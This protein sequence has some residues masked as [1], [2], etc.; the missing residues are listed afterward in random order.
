MLTTRP[1]KPL[2]PRFKMSEDCISLPLIRHRCL[3]KDITLRLI[4]KRRQ[5]I[6]IISNEMYIG[7]IILGSVQM[8][9]Q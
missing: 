5:L 2:M 4:V 6:W 9:T 7:I 8:V 3:Y 1:P